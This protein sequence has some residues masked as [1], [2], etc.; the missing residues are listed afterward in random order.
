MTF[1][2]LL[3][4]SGIDPNEVCVIR[5]QTPSRGKIHATVHDLW[6]DNIE[7]FHRYQATQEA[8][9]PIFRT[10]KIWAAF[11][12]PTPND[13]IFVGL[14][15]ASLADTR[16]ADWLCDYQ[17]EIPGG[18]KPVDIFSTHLRTE[19][20]EQIG[21]LQVDWPKESQRAWKRYAETLYL[22]ITTGKNIVQFGATSRES[23]ING[24]TELGFSRTHNTQKLVE[25]RRNELLVYVK[26]DTERQPLVIHPHYIDLA[27]ELR[28]LKGVTVPEPLTVYK[29]SNLSAF[30]AFHAYN[31]SS[32]GRY[33]FAIGVDASGLQALVDLL[34]RGSKV[35]TPDG[36]LNVVGPAD[37][38]VTERKQLQ[39]ARVG[40]GAFRDALMFTWKYACPVTGVDQTA[41]LR[42]SH[43]KPWRDASNA[44]RL[45]P[46]NGI[47]LCAHID[48]LFDQN[49]ITFEDDGRIRISSR[50]SIHNRTRL[51]LDANCRI[52]GLDD[53]HAPFLEHH[54]M[55]FLA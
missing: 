11:I 1:N 39:A 10:R 13:T 2:D 45:D 5:H 19:L 28:A 20:S 38:P 55:R 23:L 43:I 31:R 52:V 9:K 48:A 27:E 44:E 47:L 25:M 50:V 16:K 26:R 4:S 49:L 37:D 21:I 22:P 30:P 17:G 32:K 40:Q 34:E 6:R 33:G 41:L 29:N 42:A 14:Y 51:G 12:R 8:E 3:L 54:R 15:D 18:G 24:L 7:G 36:E 35:A 53:R 46:D